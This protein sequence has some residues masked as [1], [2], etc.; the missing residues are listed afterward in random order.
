[1]FNRYIYL[2]SFV[3]IQQFSFAQCSVSGKVTDST[4][5]PIP[6]AAIAILKPQDSSIV[7]GVLTNDTGK[8]V[9]DN[10]LPGSYVLKIAATGFVERYSNIIKLD[11]G[12]ALHMQVFKLKNNGNNLKAVNVIAD[13]PFAEQKMDRTVYNIGNNDMGSGKSATEILQ[14]LPGVI[15]PEEGNI[16]V[17]GKTG[18]MI[19]IDGRPTYLSGQDANDYLKSIDASQIDR[20]EIITSPSVKYDAAGSAIINIIMKK[21]ANIG[22]HGNLSATDKQ[23]YY[24]TGSGSFNANYRTKTWN[25][26][27]NGGLNSSHNFGD[28]Y[29]TRYFNDAIPRQVF[30]EYSVYTNYGYS[31][32]GRFGIDFMPDDNQTIGVV[33]NGSMSSYSSYNNHSIAMYSL[34]PSPDSSTDAVGT[35]VSSSS[36]LSYSLNYKYKIDSTG[37]EFS[38]VAAYNTSMSSPNSQLA[39]YYYDSASTYMR[40]PYLFNQFIPHTTNTKSAQMDY[41]Q[42]FGKKCKL[43]VGVKAAMGVTDNNAQYWTINQ[44]EE[45]TDTTKSN[46]FNLAENIYS[47]YLNFSDQLSRKISFSLGIRAENTQDKGIQYVHDSVFTRN[48]YNA[49]PSNSASW[50]I[51]TNNTLSMSFGEHIYRPSYSELNPFLQYM[52][53]YSYYAGNINLQPEITYDYRL[54]YSLKSL[55]TVSADYTHT[56][57]DINWLWEQN[58]IT[59]ISYDIPLNIASSDSYYGS[60]SFYKVIKKIWTTT[61]YLSIHQSV[62]NGQAEGTSYGNGSISW[63]CS[64]YNTFAFKKGWR[65]ELNFYYFA[66]SVY[67]FN[68]QPA[69]YALNATISKKIADERGAIKIGLS[70]ILAA[71]T[72]STTQAYLNTNVHSTYYNYPRNATITLTWKLGKIKH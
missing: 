34:N 59:H 27:G 61:D 29:I 9:I 41:T 20:I 21:G 68:T 39:N 49:F 25:F 55:I 26:F 46:H 10:I 6:Y 72:Y 22:F 13:K 63:S 60:I 14:T 31:P 16:S 18:V 1:M 12:N 3:T 62:Y 51:D 33:A 17:A 70:N 32:N 5:S 19:M 64:S 52:N 69:F 54:T 66:P 28:S 2:L 36:N 67:G 42:P 56:S 50:K 40:A 15:A 38:A 58:D 43:E 30:Q 11:D 44:G 23:A 71:E 47:G 37:Q 45:V 65:A 4:G 35:G 57:N 48:Y 8:Y 7:K 24:N 53:P